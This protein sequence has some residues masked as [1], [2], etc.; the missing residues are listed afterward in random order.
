M[1][2]VDAFHVHVHFEQKSLIKI[3]GQKAQY[4]LMGVVIYEKL[5]KRLAHYSAFIRSTKNRMKWFYV[6]DSHVSLYSA[7]VLLISS[8]T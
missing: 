7:S 8:R 6:N 4:S 3:P 1:Y 2:T 5:S